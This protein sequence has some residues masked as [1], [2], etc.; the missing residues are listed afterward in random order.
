MAETHSYVT[1]TVIEIT[2]P[3]YLHPLDE[4]NSILVETLLGASNYR[5]WRSSFKIGLAS[6][7]KLGFVT[8]ATSRDMADSVKQ[9][10]WDT[11]N[12]MII[13]WI[14]NGVSEPI[15]KSIIFLD[16]AHTIW[17]QLEQRFSVTNGSRKYKLSKEIFETK[18]LDRNLSEYYVEI[19]GLWEEIESL[20]VLP[21]ITQ[22]ATEFKEFLN[23]LQTQQDEQRLFQFLNGLDDSYETHRSHILMQQPLPTVDEAYNVL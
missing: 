1:P 22:V 14:L 17:I 6:K 19:R 12:N 3:L 4:S 18:Q 5:S 13:S 21:A 10:A 11:C 20:N 2:S 16:N 7:R 15:K 9:E 8:G 23:A